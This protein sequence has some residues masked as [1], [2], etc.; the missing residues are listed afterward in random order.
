MSWNLY[1]APGVEVKGAGARL[2]PAGAHQ[3]IKRVEQASETNL[4]GV[5]TGIYTYADGTSVTFIATLLHSGPHLAGQIHEPDT[6][7]GSGGAIE[8]ALDGRAEG[9]R[10]AFIKRYPPAPGFTHTVRYEGA[11]SADGLEIDGTW[12]LPAVGGSGRFLMTRNGGAKAGASR[13]EH[14]AA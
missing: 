3:T 9:G 2:T 12:R 6:F 11:V 5:W 4:T 10:V 7:T 1:S 14:A 8:A 13:R